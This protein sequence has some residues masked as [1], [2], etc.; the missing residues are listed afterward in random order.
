MVDLSKRCIF[1][2]RKVERISTLIKENPDI[3][4]TEFK[5]ARASRQSSLLDSSN[6]LD[7]VGNHSSLLDPI[8]PGYNQRPTTPAADWS[9]T[10]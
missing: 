3:D 5:F 7:G 6:E 2:N 1:I 10:D 8:E 9:F 4:F